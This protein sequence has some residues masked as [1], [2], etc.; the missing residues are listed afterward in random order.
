[1]GR[2]GGKYEKGGVRGGESHAIGEGLDE[3]PSPSAMSSTGREPG[4]GTRAKP[5]KGRAFCKA[6]T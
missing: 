4:W 6:M 2:N 5:W 3:G 1:M